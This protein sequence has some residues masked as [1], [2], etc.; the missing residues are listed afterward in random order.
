MGYNRIY[1]ASDAFDEEVINNIQKD[2]PAYIM[3]FFGELSELEQ[4]EQ[5]LPSTLKKEEIQDLA[6]ILFRLSACCLRF[7]DALVDGCYTIPK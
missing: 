5:P 1:E 7:A 2:M 6:N 4:M 3:S